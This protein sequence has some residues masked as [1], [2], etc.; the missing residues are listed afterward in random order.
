MG[1]IKCKECKKK[2]SEKAKNCPSCG[3]PVKNRVGCGGFIVILFF[4]GVALYNLP[5]IIPP[6][7][8]SPQSKTV[9]F[10]TAEKVKKEKPGDIIDYRIYSGSGSTYQVLVEKETKK[11][12]VIRLAKYLRNKHS[13]S[14]FIFIAI[15]N[16]EEALENKI[17]ESYSTKR[18]MQHFLIQITK[19]NNTGFDKVIWMKNGEGEEIK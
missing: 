9:Q 13:S 5:S 14:S 7:K 2:V 10:N 11:E 15:F 3:A 19:N 1:L 18:V 16:D 12:D 4:M 8:I 6:V 17:N